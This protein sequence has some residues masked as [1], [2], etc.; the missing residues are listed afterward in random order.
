MQRISTITIARATAI[1]DEA[2]LK[3]K[4][5]AEITAELS[6]LPA[7]QVEGNNQVD[8]IA[9]AT[10]EES[11]SQQQQQTPAAVTGEDVPQR[12][13]TIYGFGSTDNTATHAAA[14][15]VSLLRNYSACLLTAISQTMDQRIVPF[16][17]SQPASRQVKPTLRK[18]SDK[19]Q[20]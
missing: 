14:I 17:T 9:L 1:D 6:S 18:L 20:L 12:S 19:L 5:I 7:T 8:D 10:N 11:T 16:I 2:D 3:E 15:V 13:S 4:P